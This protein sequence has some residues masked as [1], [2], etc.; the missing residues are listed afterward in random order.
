MTSSPRLNRWRQAIALSTAGWLL[1]FSLWT[2]LS[3]SASSESPDITVNTLPSGQQVYVQ[4]IH[5]QP[6][7]TIDTWVNTGSA[8]ETSENN[9]VSHFLE[10]LLFKGTPTY[11]VGQIDRILESRGAEFNAATS[12]DFTHYHI[13]TASPY[14]QEALAMHADMLLNATINPPE[15][16]RE[17][18]VVQEEINRALDNPSRKGYI[19][20]S[21]ALFGP[22]PYAMDTLGPKSNIQ[23]LSRESILNYYHTW[24]QPKN[25]KTVIVGDINPH[26]ATHMVNAAFQKAYVSQQRPHTGKPQ[27]NAVTP[28]T[29][30]TSVVLAD[31]NLS[32]VQF[33]LGF[34]APS[35]ANR[36]ENY[37]LDVAAMVLGQGAS[38]RLYQHVKED[39]QLVN[40]IAA[41]NATM[42]Q[43]GMFYVGAEIQPEKREAAQ[44]AILA[45]ITRFLQEGPT[46]EELAKAKT[47]VVKEFAFSTESTDGVASSIGYNVTIGELDDY[48]SYVGNIQK[49][50]ADDVKAAA[51]K[52]VDFDK[53]VLVEVLP[54]QDERAFAGQAERNIAMLRE[55]SRSVTNAMTAS[56]ATPEPAAAHVRKI[57][58]ANG[59]TL[60]LKPSPTTKTVAFSIF[61]KGGRLGEPKPGVAALTSRLMMKGTRNRTAKTLSQ[62]LEKLGLSLGVSSDEDYLHI[63]G[64]SV[65]DDFGKLLL[66]LQDV[67]ANPTFPQDELEKERADLLED[68]KTSRDQPSSLMFEKLTETLYTQHPYGAVG[69]RLEASLPNVTREDVQAFYRQQLRPENLVIAVAGNFDPE[70]V[71]AGFQQV[72]SP[73]PPQDKAAQAHYPEVRPLLDTVRV[74]AKKPEQAASWVAYGWLAPGISTSRDY[75]TLKVINSLLGGGLSSRLFVDLREKQGLAYHVSSMF[76][77]KLK[78]GSFVMYIGTDPRNLEQVQTGFDTEIQRLKTEPVSEEE[79]EA[80]KSKLMGSFALAH[81]SNASQAMYL[82]LYETLGVGYGFDTQYP[83]LIKQVTATD[84]QRVAKGVFSQPKVV[85]IV[86]PQVVRSDSPSHEN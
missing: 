46:P 72:V 26:D 34:L 21:K 37:A 71:K 11:Q 42:Q 16:D 70:Q 81:E 29:A 5:T 25:F 24:Y 69:K 45:E 82:G 50:T 18:K 75:I 63:N 41:G 84:V 85:S 53:A 51:R 64:A 77:S 86:A 65:S 83:N 57:T 73:L 13:T 3:W 8:Q 55:A 19:A 1:T 66:I 30:S 49:I 44:K 78:N 10:H 36:Q 15:L 43:A 6:I 12:D 59:A 20:L 48:T 35:V 4:E 80:V 28:R 2:P 76:P 60:L 7:V 23:T 54:G 22:H 14:F 61:A 17:R 38:S 27:L 67:V 52:Y 9:G 58:L 56:Q 74:E 68:I 32:A 31:P 39:K 79:L 33:Q 62:E 47:Q 40:S